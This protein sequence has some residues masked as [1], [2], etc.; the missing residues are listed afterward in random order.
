MQFIVN[1]ANPGQFNRPVQGFIQWLSIIQDA[2]II[3]GRISRIIWLDVEI[4]RQG[5]TFFCFPIL[6]QQRKQINSTMFRGPQILKA[7][8]NN[9]SGCMYSFRHFIFP[10]IFTLVFRLVIVQPHNVLWMIIRT[11]MIMI[12]SR[13]IRFNPVTLKILNSIDNIKIPIFDHGGNQVKADPLLFIAE[14]HRLQ[15][16]DESGICRLQRF[17]RFWR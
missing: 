17:N 9:L 14:V 12:I 7:H 15:F 4:F 1:P 11:E 5:Y 8:H 16:I 10:H 13:Q 6:F 3:G 2:R